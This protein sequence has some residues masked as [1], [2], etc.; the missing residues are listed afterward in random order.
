MALLCAIFVL[1]VS[2]V[3]CIILLSFNTMSFCSVTCIDDADQG[4][5]DDCLWSIVKTFSV[6]FQLKVLASVTAKM[7]QC[8]SRSLRRQRNGGTTVADELEDTEG[9]EDGDGE[10]F[11]SSLTIEDERLWNEILN[12][13]GK[14]LN[15]RVNVLLNGLPEDSGSEM[16]TENQQSG[17]DIVCFTTGKAHTAKA[18]EQVMLP[19]F[20][21][22]LKQVSSDTPLAN[23][24]VL[25]HYQQSP[26]IALAS[27]DALLDALRLGS[28][29]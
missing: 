19:Q 9:R 10:E 26:L 15:K 24:S 5:Q 18:F 7:S 25:D 1:G 28:N 11:I 20:R 23:K 8:S 16:D 14:D 3:E 29:G 4:Q 6:E 27:P 21:L 17:V 12:N 2:T 13:L 22:Q